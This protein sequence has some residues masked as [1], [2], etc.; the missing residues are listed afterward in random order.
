MK[1]FA[2]FTLL[3]ACLAVTVAG[4][5]DAPAS[6]GPRPMTVEDLWA[7]ER[8]GNPVPSPDGSQI[9]FTVSTYSMEDN[10]STRHLWM[11]PTDGSTAP[12]RLTWSDAKDGSSAWSPDGRYLAFVS[13]RGEGPPQ[14]FRL[15]MDGPGEAEPITELPIGVRDPRWLPD[16]SGLI[17]AANTFP[18]LNDDFEKVKERLDERE[19]DE[20]DAKIT[21]TRLLRYW[22]HYRTDGTVTHLFHL[23]LET[24]EVRDL[25]SG[26]NNIMGFGG[27]DWDLSPE[28]DEIAFA[29]NSTEPPYQK[30]DFN[31]FLLDM[32]SGAVRSITD[33]N[34][35]T[36]SAPS[37]APDGTLYF[38][39]NRRPEIAPDFSRLV[40][41]DREADAV[42]EVLPD[43]DTQLRG[44]IFSADSQTIFFHAQE[45]GRQG[46]YSVPASGGTP[47]RLVQGGNT[48]GVKRAGD[49][50]VFLEESFY[51]PD[52][53]MR[54][55]PNGEGKA[56]LVGLNDERLAALDLGSAEDVTF[57]GADGNDVQMFVLTPPG[58]DPAQKWPL[59]IAVHG[60]PHGA[61]LDSFHYRWNMALF[62]SPGYVVAALNF[63]G[64]SGFGQAYAESILGNHADKPFE[65]VM[66]ATDYLLE[67]YPIDPE[68]MG[69]AGGS[70]GGYLVSWILGPYQPLRHF[71]EPRRGLRPDGAIRQ[72]LHLESQ[73]QLRCRSLGKSQ[74][75]RPLLPEP[76]RQELRDPHSHPARRARLPGALYPRREPAS[77]A[78]RQ[79]GTVAHRDLP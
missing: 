45:R 69:A 39:R 21:E 70:Y 16:G 18:D 48:G 56:R 57:P 60:G 25:L 53:L 7:M 4:G 1:T 76:L 35:A 67:N 10:S 75:Y 33:D 44:F 8:I 59:L 11:V 40:R 47:Q 3:F 23:D 46:L 22:D 72:R 9:V 77:G 55:D 17:F 28:G 73:Q 41:Y 6:E 13:K 61:W 5:S 66:K 74:P 20:I 19:E 71:G 62:A 34:P 58:Y 43:L 12:R 14:L 64:S 52:E 54:I 38:T 51:R 79:G 42:V 24:R 30:L 49:V 65:D 63:H 15:P 68:R 78:H 50:L 26:Y 27:F 32:E 29:A 36:D 2:L 37:Y 31:L